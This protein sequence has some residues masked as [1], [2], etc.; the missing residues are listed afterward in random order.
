MSRPELHSTL[1]DLVIAITPVAGGTGMHVESA[2]LAVPLEAST[3]LGPDGLVVL[4]R[5]A[6]SRWKSGFLPAT[7]L[8][9][10]VIVPA[11]EAP[12]P[13]EAADER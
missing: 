3:A 8:S 12:A 6:H 4:A 10:L 9:R 2:E 11:S 1:V 13:E 7:S 5:V